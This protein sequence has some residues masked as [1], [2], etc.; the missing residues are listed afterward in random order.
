MS[1]E[2][3]SLFPNHACLCLS[4]PIPKLLQLLLPHIPSFS[5]SM[6]RRGNAS[7]FS[8]PAPLLSYCGEGRH[9]LPLPLYTSEKSEKEGAGWGWK[10]PV[11]KLKHL[12]ACAGWL[13]I[14]QGGLGVG[15]GSGE[16]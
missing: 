13:L 11:F 14:R 5:F 1:Q 12:Q 8:L 6:L 10:N 16:K 7:L 3:A 9:L 15:G 2:E 4:L